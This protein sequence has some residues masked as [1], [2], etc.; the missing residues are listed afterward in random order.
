MRLFIALQLDDE[1][2]SALVSAQDTLRENRVRGAFSPREN[3]HITML[4]IGEYGSAEPVLDA[5][6][7]VVFEPF[8]LTL[9]GKIGSF[10]DILWAGTEQSNSLER[11]ERRLRRALSDAGIPFDRK[12][13]TPHITLLRRTEL[14]DSGSFAV[15]DVEISPVTMTVNE[16]TL[17]RSD[18]GRH[19]M[20]YTELGSIAGV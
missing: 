12:S 11:L 3:L 10:G 9:S 15:S 17:F 16:V 1:M 6:D 5:M 13:F 7:K 2:R 18:R 19:G 20:I 14:P 4:F 8:D